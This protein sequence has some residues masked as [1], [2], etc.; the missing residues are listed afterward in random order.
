MKKSR[1]TEE[2]IIG[3]PVFSPNV[4]QVSRNLRVCTCLIESLN[5]RSPIARNLGIFKGLSRK[6]NV[7]L[8]EGDLQRSPHMKRCCCGEIERQT[9]AS[10]S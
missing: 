3:I 9:T 2:Q 1:Y 8:T 7:I 4:I 6:R 5:I 10:G